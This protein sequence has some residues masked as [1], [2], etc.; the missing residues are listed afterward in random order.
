MLTV[1]DL[2][3]YLRLTSDKLDQEIQD[4]MDAA[5]LDLASAGMNDVDNALVDMA[6]KL[7]ARWKFNYADKADQYRRDYQELKA[8]LALV[9][10]Q[11]EED[12]N[13]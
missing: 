10:P 13:V 2:R 6:I 3:A 1:Q 5:K 4:T 11:G 7:Y 8:A 12:Q 9:Y